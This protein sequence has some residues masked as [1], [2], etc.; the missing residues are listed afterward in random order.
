MVAPEPTLAGSANKRGGVYDRLADPASFTGVYRR[1]WESDGR[2]NGFATA[3]SALPG[4]PGDAWGT[5]EPVSD[6]AQL[7]RPNLR[8]GGGAGGGTPGRQWRPPR[9]LTSP[10]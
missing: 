6:L 3:M 4:V 8:S 9:Q 10:L 1:A 7:V 2:M 5:D